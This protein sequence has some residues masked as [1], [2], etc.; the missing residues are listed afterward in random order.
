M[1]QNKYDEFQAKIK[2]YEIKDYKIDITI[3][4]Q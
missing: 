2:K 1:T 4:N 3:K